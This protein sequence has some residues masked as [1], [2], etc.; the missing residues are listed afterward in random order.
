MSEF[1]SLAHLIKRL[2]VATTR[3]EDLA[4]SASSASAVSSTSPT[5]TPPPPSAPAV[6]QPTGVSEVPVVIEK[7]DE[8]INA[9]LQKYLAL[10]A[11]IGEPIS[12]QATLVASAIQAER[13]IL[14]ISTLAQKPVMSTTIFGKLI[15]PLQTLLTEVVN[16]KEKNRGSAMF[17]HLSTVAE[18]IPALGW[19]TCE[20]APSPFIRDMKDAAQFYANRVAK[21]WKEKDPKHVEWSQAFLTVLDNL[22][23]FV[24]ENYPTG[25]PWNPKGENLETYM[26]QNNTSTAVLEEYEA[27]KP[28]GAAAVFA[29][30]NKGTSVTAGLRKVDKSQMTHKNP[31][32]RAG[33]SIDAGSNKKQAPPT[34]S[35]PNKYI[36][37]KPAR[38][39]LE[40]NKW[41]V[42]NHENN[43]TIV[44]EDT[45]INQ[46]V[47]IFGCKNSTIRI[48]GKVNAVTMDSCV[49][50]GIAIDSTVSTVDLV[51]CK[52]FA[53]QVFHVTPTIA[54]DKCDSGEIYLSKECLG[55]EIL[56][57]K[58]SSLNV[59]VP[60][61]IEA[62][63]S[64]MK[65]LFVPEQ[66]KTTIVDGKLVTTLIEHA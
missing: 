33:S 6:V 17:N 2:E 65:E 44:I 56:S 61:D 29:E 22:G 24:K 37:K 42:E 7:Q 16:I 14:R 11:E 18:G 30:I 8:A 39:T 25:L 45:A 36:L 27:G 9:A 41:V 35:K 57:A 3:L 64:E 32:L 19:F 58:S 5:N 59:L 23:R 50:C 54:V 60:E 49:K 53:L 15:D 55:V 31:S 26:S 38:T 40:A 13:D 12:K 21:E 46:A 52:S 4:L 28:T 51:N 20:P 48:K 66:L 47:Y 1:H 34:P 63:D 10:S 62:E 43:N